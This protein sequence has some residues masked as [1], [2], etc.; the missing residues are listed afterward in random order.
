MQTSI[1]VNNTILPTSLGMEMQS[2][3]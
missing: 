3:H 1:Y 2:I